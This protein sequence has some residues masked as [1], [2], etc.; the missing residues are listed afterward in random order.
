MMF[1]LILIPT[2]TVYYGPSNFLWISDVA[3]ILSF[4]AVVFESRLF[5]SMAAVGGLILETFWLTAFLSLMLFNVHLTDIADYMFDASIPLGLRLLSL[6]HIA[7]PFLFIW[8]VMRLGY[9][10]KAVMLQIALIW[11]ILIFCATMTKPAENINWVYS[12]KELNM[13]PVLYLILEGLGISLLLLFTHG[14]L[15]LFAQK[16]TSVQS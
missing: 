8:L 5:A 3:L 11:G 12:Y 14:F 15:M 7:L 1:M 6:F 10:R 16:K 13:N 9:A 2:Y 4:L